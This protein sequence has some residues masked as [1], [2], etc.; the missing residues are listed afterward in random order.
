MSYA[1]NY[2]PRSGIAIIGIAGRFPGARTVTEFWRNVETGLESISFF[3]PEELEFSRLES[4]TLRGDPQYVRARGII[5][6]AENFDAAF[7]AINL[8]EAELM[9]PQ[10]RIFLE[11]AWEALED[12]GYDPHVHKGLIGVFAG[13]TNNTYFPAVISDWPHTAEGAAALRTMMGNEKDYLATRV[14]YELNLRG[15]SLNI[16]T[17]CS[18]SL[19][20]I[21]QAYQ[22]LLSFQ[23]DMALAGG[24][25]VTCPQKRGYLHY[26]G[27]ITSPDGHCRAFDASAQGTVFSNGVGIVV[28]KRLED[29]LADGDQIYAVVKGAAV[30]NDGAERVSFA[31]PNI[32]GQAEVVAMAQAMAGIDPETINYVEAHGTGTALGDPVEIA[33]L[34]QA[35]RLGTTETGF[36][37]IGSVKT[38]IGHLDV[39]AGVAGLIKTVLA[40]KHKKLPPS[41]HF[42]SPNPKIDF[43]NSPFYVNTTLKDWSAESRP[44][45]AGVSSFGSGGTNAHVVLEEAPAHVDAAPNRPE[46]VL[47]MSA[48]TPGA[49]E[50]TTKKLAQYL[51]EHPQLHWADVAFTLQIGRRGFEHRRMV[52]CGDR[53]DAI[54]ALNTLEPARVLTRRARGADT[55]VAFMFPGQGSQY[56][57]MGRGLYEERSLF[58]KQISECAE[59]LLPQLGVDIRSVLY[60]DPAQAELAEQQINQTLITQPLLFAVEYSLAKLWIHWGIRPGYLIGHS[61][62][63]YVAAALAGVFSRDEALLLLAGRARLMHSLSPGAMLA[64]RLPSIE[65]E[66]RLGKNLSVAAIN[67]PSV[68]VISGGVEEVQALQDQLELASIP[69]QRLAT[70]HAF[71]SPMMDSILRPFGELLGR[72]RLN[73]PEV[74]WIS[75]LSGERITA[76]QATD[77]DYWVQQIRQ[78]VRFADGMRALLQEPVLNLLEAGPGQALGTL[79]RQHPDRTAE[80]EILH[81][82]STERGPAFDV[83]SMLHSLG[84]LWLSGATVDWACV[85]D[86]RPRRRITLPAYP[87]ESKRLWPGAPA[88]ANEPGQHD[89]LPPINTFPAAAQPNEPGFSISDRYQLPSHENGNGGGV[90]PR[91]R[92]L[93]GELAGISAVD[94]DI[95]AP[96][97]ELGLD[98]LALTQA[99]AAIQKAF[100][101]KVTFRQLLEEF[102]S[103]QALASHLHEL[104]PPEKTSPTEPNVLLEASQFALPSGNGTGESKSFQQLVGVNQTAL[105]QIVAKQLELMSRQLDMLQSSG[106]GSEPA[107]LDANRGAAH[108]KAMHEAA[109]P[110]NL[111]PG[112]PSQHVDLRPVA[113]AQVKPQSPGFGPYK[114]ITKGVD[115]ALTRRQR[116][117]LD[118]LITRYNA[119]T[120]ESKRL[121]SQYRLRLADPRTVAGFRLLWKELVYPIVTERSAGSRLWDVDGNEYVDLTNGFG[122][123]LFGH[124][125]PFVTRAIQE[126]LERGMEIG[127]QSPLAGRVAEL[128]CELSGMERAAFCNTGSEAVLA[129]LRM[130]RTVTGRD[131]IALFSG[132]YHGIFDEVVVRSVG[133]QRALKARPA[134]PG[135]PSN[136]AEN[137]MVLDYGNFESLEILRA[138]AHELAAVIVEPVQ[139]RRLDLQP[140]EYLQE[141][142]ALTAASGIALIFDEIVTGF[143]VHQGGAQALFGIK[144]DIATYGKVIGG[145]LPIGVVAGKAAYMDA[146]DGGSWNY[147]DDSAPEVGVTF[148]AGTFVRHPLALA[149]AWACLNHL[150]EHSP[151]LQLRLNQRTQRLVDELTAHAREMRAPLRINHFSSLFSFEFPPDLPYASLFYI[152]MRDKG[153]HLWEGR[154][155]VLTTAHSDEDIARVSDAFK[156]SIGEMQEAGFLP[157]PQNAVVATK[158]PQG[159]GI[160]ASSGFPLTDAQR[161]IWLATRMGDDASRAFVDSM[162]LHLRGPVQPHVMIEAIRQLVARHDALRSVFA[163]S[164]EERLVFEVTELD[165]PVIDLSRMAPHEQEERL[166]KIAA[167]E[168]QEPFDLS[169]GPL[170]RGCI[171]KL[172]DEHQVAFLSTH[173]IAVDGWS[174]GVLLTELAALYSAGSARIPH[175]LPAARQ[176]ADYLAWEENQRRSGARSTS[177]TYWLEQFRESVQ[178][179]QLPVDR[180]RPALKTYNAARQQL[181]LPEELCRSLRRLAAERGSTLFATL[182]AAFSALLHRLTGQEDIVVGIPTAGQMAFHAPDLVGHCV[183][184]LPLRNRIS[185]SASFLEHLAAVKALVLDAYDHQDYTYGSLLE[186]LKISRDRSRQPL[187]SVSFNLDRTSGNLNFGNL[188]VEVVLLPRS[189]VNFDCEININETRTELTVNWL[190]NSDLFQSDTIQRWSQHYRTLLEGVVARPDREIAHLPLLT[191]PE[192][193]QLLIEWNDTKTDYPRNK[194]VHE[195]FEAQVDRIPDAVA[196]V[197]GDQQLTYGELNRRANQLAHFLRGLG[198]GSESL[199]GICLERSFEMVIALLGILKAGAAYVPLDTGYPKE[200]LSFMIEDAK[201]AVLLTQQPLIKNLPEHAAT[202][203][204][205]DT[206]WQIVAAES[207]ENPVPTSTPENLAYVI[208]TSGSTGRPKGVAVPHR[209]ITRLLIAV[210]Y[211]KLDPTQVFFHLAPISFDAATFELWGALLHGAKCVLYP[212][213]VPT[214]ADLKRVLYRYKISILWLTASLFNTVIDEAPEALSEVRQLLIGGEALSLRH[215]RR[216]LEQ[217]PHTQIINGYG[218]T[219][220]TTFTCSYAVPRQLDEAI[221]SVPIGRPI[222]NTRVYIL[223]ARLQPVPVGVPAE[224]YIGGDGLARAYLNR[225]E[226]T[227]E[228]FIADPFGESGDRLYKTGD[229]V[230]Y[231]PDGIIEFLGRLDNQV[232]IRGFRIEPGE[233]ETLL[234]RYAGVRDTVVLAREHAPGDKRLVAYVVGEPGH[235]VS[236]HELRN[237]LKQQLPEYMVPSA[238]VFL[239][240][241]P[242]TPNGKLDD[243]ALPDPAS[244]DASEFTEYVAP[245]DETERILCRVWS[246]VL[247]VGRV[248]LDD[249][250]F[251]IGG[252]SLLAARLFARLDEIFGHSLPLGVLFSAPTVRTLAERYRASMPLKIRSIV[253][254]RTTGTRPPVYAVPGVFGNVVGFSDLAREL[255]PEQP[256][257]GLQSVGLDGTEAPFDSIGE[258]AKLYVSEMRSVHPGGPYAIIGACF[259]ATVAYEMAR[260]MLEEGDEVA[261]LGLLGPTDREGH[262]ESENHKP[263]PRSYKRTLALGNFVTGRLRLYRDEIQRRSTRD[264]IQFL[265]DKMRSLGASITNRNRLKG[266]RRELNQIEVYQANLLALDRY[267]RKPMTGRLRALEIFETESTESQPQERFD[268]SSFWH[269]QPKIHYVAGKDSGDMLSEKNVPVLAALLEKRLR[270]VFGDALTPVQRDSEYADDADGVRIDSN[271]P[272]S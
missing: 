96:F 50:E 249:D 135:I 245:R 108:R 263:V 157:A 121:T 25:S 28:L 6:G 164:G 201:L 77:P 38:N 127:P 136:M 271:Y 80:H 167:R 142:R 66:P 124:A 225:P 93:F 246:E 200:R 91:L 111:S 123:I 133:P 109:R 89:N 162:A 104:L 19:V 255:G 30:N 100:G 33:G 224:L 17:A 208:Y 68:T 4:S 268:W 154:V 60:P 212:G 272:R 226:L 153:I 270:A 125:P 193:R 65:L 259:G 144:A 98:S 74:Q 35:F 7:F 58:Y 215:V 182:L 222:S 23:C 18:T 87:F 173:H 262:G 69:C 14:S 118:A 95:S 252:H 237:R 166:A 150:K 88:V 34:T 192:R 70:S 194:C 161:E 131:K 218:P 85:H 148:F 210:D 57:N 102:S 117:C 75:T 214:P 168:S 24:I 86:H 115:Q 39:A 177:E 120:K 216:A 29:A 231:G 257:Y 13:M 239:A 213:T 67:S 15:A 264:R 205:I 61:L 16:Q 219:E 94:M 230:R 49:L 76:A 188:N 253:G 43:A 256:F 116:E 266:A 46:Q 265:M 233:I 54:H 202:T 59:V 20:S 269:G 31:A 156:A 165:V 180:S 209:G 198:V 71:H 229:L 170:L 37:A 62:G 107:I 9:D 53:A 139:S 184:F 258:M 129:A 234:G 40:L 21:C 152:Y 183:N 247:R 235:H 175:G 243:R 1:E 106:R 146:L 203:L 78:P 84:R 83:R 145:G 251:A 206:D 99:S 223:D 260:L 178:D 196:L 241:L 12:A 47:V 197:L 103:L 228:R 267:H 138:H 220:S 155:G 132:D 163:N 189:S 169:K 171:V 32:Q 236:S 112:G 140:I 82:L 113:P 97:L 174:L 195:L 134:A 159:N 11:T 101:I 172:H 128:L 64:V 199:V 250:F 44:R 181:V 72:L 217:L 187:V 143:R 190:Y 238:F 261:F 191:G 185:G 244:Q 151:E 176:F 248:G 27:A 158:E 137:V 41:L 211:V 204:C 232:K 110:G 73:A 114:P 56:V 45:R 36:C 3:T 63:E 122:V 79:A 51:Q 227:A 42:C 55:G 52:V 240:S 126:Q 242:L 160:A 221:R 105:E 141:L 186:K 22:S 179:L 147:G 90:L 149:A 5:D 254:L 92:D 10:Q 48:R 81:S 130:A 2:D 119:R 8:R 26:E 207:A